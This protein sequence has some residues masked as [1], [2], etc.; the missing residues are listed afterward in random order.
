[1]HECEGNW[2]WYGKQGGERFIKLWTR[3]YYLMPFQPFLITA[4]RQT[5]PIL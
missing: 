4:D 1:M 3:I 5:I 2:F